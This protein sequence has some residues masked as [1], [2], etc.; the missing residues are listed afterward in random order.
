METVCKTNVWILCIVVGGVPRSYMKISSNKLTLENK[1][2]TIGMYSNAPK[3]VSYESA[4]SGPYSMYLPYYGD[5]EV[6][7]ELVETYEVYSKEHCDHIYPSWF[8]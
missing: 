8:C 4:V 6:S 3:S 1:L 7:Y 5:V 2:R